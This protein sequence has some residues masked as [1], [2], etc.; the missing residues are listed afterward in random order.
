LFADAIVLHEKNKLDEAQSLY[1]KVIEMDNSHVNALHMLGTIYLERGAA[2]EAAVLI[3]K[4]LAVFPQQPDAWCNLGLCLEKIEDVNGALVAYEK[5][6]QLRPNF[7]GALYNRAG[8]LRKQRHFE[9]ALSNIEIAI[10]LQPGFV[11]AINNKG[12]LLTDMGKIEEAIASFTQAIALK[13]DY[14][15]TYNNRGVCFWKL[16]RFE[17]A[18]ADYDKALLIKPD[19]FSAIL[20]RATALYDIGNYELAYVAVKKALLMQPKYSEACALQF[21]IAAR[22]CDWEEYTDQIAAISTAVTQN[23]LLS[24]FTVLTAIDNAS[25]QYQAAKRWAASFDIFHKPV[26]KL[27]KASVKTRSDE[28]LRIA[29]LSA[30]FQEHAVAYSMARIFECHDKNRFDCYAI[31][32][33][34]SKSTPMRER[35]ISA[36]EHFVDARLWSDSAIVEYILQQKIDIL[37]DLAGYTQGSRTAVLTKKPA[38]VQI[39]Y[40]GYPGTLGL[41]AIDYIIADKTVIPESNFQFFSEKVIHVGGSYLCSD[42]TRVL[43]EHLP[44]RAELSLPDNGFVFCCFNHHYKITP[45]WFEIWMRLL[46]AV[47]NSVLWLSAS[48]DLAQKNLQQRAI[49]CGID[50]N[51]LI[52]AV[53][54]PDP[55]QHLSRLRQA[56]LFLDTLPYNAHATATDALWAG[57]PLLTCVGKSFPA[58]VAASL[59]TSMGLPELITD[60]PEAYEARAV[61]LALYPEQLSAIRNKLAIQKVHSSLFDAADSAQKLECAYSAAWERY[62]NGLQPDYIDLT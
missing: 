2:K 20:N 58:R 45:Q 44:S 42:P 33:G 57:I 10:T 56:D 29:Y 37:I 3:K 41:S 46:H 8:L 16:K 62:D 7:P 21:N 30:D 39:N 24:P 43:D 19:Y 17:E 5:S 6:L 28:R 55:S 25:I 54:T 40:L 11:D 38:A 47:N 52:F 23:E 36:F 31:S 18:I 4:S 34:T 14:G 60:S 1:R 9:A 59:L 51:R 26:M 13:P 50:S 27:P 32:L 22:L 53:R 35:L 49:A 12:N 48:N 61:E 15:E